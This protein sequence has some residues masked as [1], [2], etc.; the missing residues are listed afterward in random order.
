M[1]VL[2]HLLDAQVAGGQLIAQR[3]A[4]GTIA[5]GHEVGL[6][7]PDQGPM[8]ERF[9]GLGA[10]IHLVR[11][12]SLRRPRSVVAA[13]RLVRDYDVLYSHTAVPGSILGDLAARRAARPHVIHVHAVP[14][15]GSG[16]VRGTVQRALLRRLRAARFVAVAP[17][18]RE[19][20]TAVGLPV[21]RI[22]VVPN[23]APDPSTSP[24][25]RSSGGTVRVGMVSRL[26]PGKG[27][28]E[29]VE[30]AAPL[31]RDGV[32]AVIGGRRGP[33]AAYE[34]GLA[35]RIRGSGLRLIDAV[36]D[37]AELLAGLDVVAI[38]SHYEGS[39]LTLFEAMA[40]GRAIVAADIPGISE[41][42]EHGRNGLLVPAR[43][44]KALGQAIDRLGRDRALR[45]RLGAAARED[46]RERFPMSRTVERCLAILREVVEGAR[47]AS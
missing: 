5:E 17:H 10:R 25:P 12:S 42:L 8:L 1:K 38:P 14:H 18:V 7:A 26:D 36:E 13:A 34:A 20:L 33:F 39:P 24:A 44:A 43:D 28:D 37:G 27:I 6:L 22:E 31:A 45:E 16:F 41:V 3:I 9:G 2:F 29:F 46:A 4:E 47:D 30:A 32:R 40:L 19:A 11:L 21:G 35:R 23:G 15:Y